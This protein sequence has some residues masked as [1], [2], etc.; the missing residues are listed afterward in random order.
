MV[1][2]ERLA[3]A[4]GLGLG[5][6]YLSYNRSLSLSARLDAVG[7]GCELGDERSCEGTYWLGVERVVKEEAP[8]G[9]VE[10]GL[11]QACAASPSFC[12]PLADLERMGIE[13]P[14]DHSRADTLY[15][16]A[17]RAGSEV[18]CE[19]VGEV[20]RPTLSIARPILFSRWDISRSPIL[21]A[22][23]IGPLPERS[24][25]TYRGRLCFGKDG[26]FELETVESSGMAS[27]DHEIRKDSA[28][29]SFVRGPRYPEGRSFCM[30]IQFNRD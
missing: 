3:C 28:D 27:F 5:C 26:A 13:R 16:V 12:A 21:H 7:S 25:V 8:F 14:V 23:D 9:L 17:C 24:N 11:E 1:E 18:A 2:Y 19:N 30:N 22:S 6:R 20:D 4:H 10:R 15:R 29:W